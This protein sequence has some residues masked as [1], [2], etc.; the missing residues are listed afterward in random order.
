VIRALYR[1]EFSLK[2]VVVGAAVVSSIIHRGKRLEAVAGQEAA[3]I[4]LR[5]EMG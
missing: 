5:L 3:K 2:V 1:H 4:I